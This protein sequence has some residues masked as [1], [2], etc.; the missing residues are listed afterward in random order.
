V[1]VPDQQQ[2]PQQP[3]PVTQLLKA[4]AAGQAAKVAIVAPAVAVTLPA[5]AAVGVVKVPAEAFVH[6]VKI[7]VILKVL[8]KLLRWHTTDSTDWLTKELTRLFPDA[9]PSTIRAA[10]ENEM[11][12]ERLFQQKAIK[13]VTAALQT[14]GELPTLEQQQQKVQAILKLE[15]HYAALRTKVM[16]ERAKAHVQNAQVKARSPAGA[17][18]MLGPTKNHTLGCL[19]LAGKSWPWSVL[20]AIQPPLHP[21]CLCSLVPLGP[22]DPPPPQAG[23]ALNMAKAAL[24][25]E[26]AIRAVADPGEIEAFLDGQDVRP[27]I[28]KAIRELQEV[29][30]KDFLHPRGRGGEWIDKP[31][32]SLFDFAKGHDAPKPPHVAPKPYVP[33][34]TFMPDLSPGSTVVGGPKKIADTVL[35]GD[36]PA[37]AKQK[38]IPDFGH[39]P[40][41]LQ[42]PPAFGS[43]SIKARG[44]GD[45]YIVKNH[46]GDRT[47]VASEL[48][49]NSVYRTL[50]IDTPTM[51]RVQTEPEPDFAQRA[52]DL[53]NEPPI[54]AEPH[55][56]ISTGIILREP[57]GRLTLIEPR[58]HYGGYIHTFPKG[59]VEPNLTPQQNAH[60]E[61]W[62]E[63]GLHAHI[64][65]VVGDFKGDTGTS[66]F[67]VGVR[68]GGEATPSDETQAIKTVTP[69]EA[70]KMLNKQRD[71]EILKAVLDQPIP[72]GKFKDTFPPE[73]PGSALAFKTVKGGKTKNID[74]PNEAL[75]NGYMAD[76]LLANRDFLGDRG[77]NVRWTDDKTPI[78]TNMGSTLGYGRKGGELHA[79]G[80]TPEEVWTMRYRGQAAGTI[81][82]NEDALRQ[83]AAHIARTLTNAKIEELTKAASYPSEADR[84]L[85][86]SALK[87]RVGWMRKFA[88]G[89]ESLPRPATGAEAR[90]QFTDAQDK[91]EVYPEEHQALEKY[92]TAAG[93]TLDDHLRSGKDFTDPERQGVKR[94]DAVLEATNAPVDTHVYLGADAAPTKDMVG[95]TFSMKSYIR[96]H[97]NINDATGNTRVRLLVPGGARMMHLDDAQKGEP[98]MLLPR[99]QRMQVQGL[100]TGPDGKQTLEAI[101]LPYHKP[102]YLPSAYKPPA[103][104][105]FKPPGAQVPFFKKGDRVEVNGN[106]ATVTGDAG[107]GMANVKLDSGKGYTVP[108]SILKRLEEAEY[109]EA[110]H[111]RGRGGKWIGK[112]GPKPPHGFTALTAAPPAPTDAIIGS[113]GDKRDDD[114]YQALAGGQALDTQKLH[115]VDG[116]YTAARQLLHQ[117][118]VDHFFAN[119]KPVTDGK[120]KAI[121]TAGGAASGKSGLAGQSSDAKFNLDIPDGAVYIN[122]DD[123]KAQLPEYDALRKM[124]RQDIA[125]AATHEESSDLAKLMTALAMEGNYPIIVDGTGNSHIGKFGRKLKAAAD[126]GYDVEARYAHV[127]VSEAVTRERARAERTGRKVAESLLREQH[128]TVAQSYTEDVSKM[129]DVHVKVYSTV[130][131]GKPTL[132]AD[133]PAGKS[134]KVLDKAQYDEHVA[135]ATA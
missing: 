18:W 42:L 45:D 110:L 13:R 117:E 14:A 57:D 98:D 105:S 61:L 5:R 58:N 21:G 50:G 92:A 72:T 24:A 44:L 94:L 35:G 102:P 106:K 65:G 28:A 22:S 121:F 27:S 47:R 33:K 76:A 43:D 128:R 59:G 55:A 54:D 89:E 63:T 82:Q 64:T 8:R 104:Q 10:V 93:R 116:K 39:I 34:E 75:G 103:Q 48:L 32:G 134:M 7:A 62:E 95:K 123:I 25:L 9:D 49:S 30:W 19:A 101:L 1:A 86:A 38:A 126:A 74:A 100:T 71:Q 66:R 77:A 125:A 40:L 119:A 87:A 113:L 84:K 96:A 70:A 83:Q 23:D 12:L 122:P 130:K 120:A 88:T 6:G 67:Y 11:K 31:G 52:E 16:M 107:K 112:L 114:A 68:T 135:K 133:K 90:T 97:T 60:K 20:D 56:R 81:P 108:F 53:P 109:T 111:P 29:K 4:A 132:I 78:R 99:N 129:P 127:P 3:Q 69:D 15:Q 37:P 118:I 17:R 36:K 26:E 73:Q 85:T 80:D 79:F 46:S 124:G 91:L 51:G 131:R 115:Q 2:Q 41:K